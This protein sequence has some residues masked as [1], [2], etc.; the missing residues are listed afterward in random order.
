MERLGIA[1]KKIIL[2]GNSAG[3]HLAALALL[4]RNLLAASGLN[5]SIVAALA[6]F[7]APLELRV[8]WS[9]PPLLMLTRMKNPVLFKL[10]NPIY[11]L[12]TAQEI[13]ILL[14]HGEKDG[15]VENENSV[16]FYDKLRELGSR[17]LQIETLKNGTHLDAAS[18]CFPDH[19]CS[20]V[21]REWLERVENRV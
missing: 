10:A 19:P 18:W 7:S 13:P 12:K 16:V 4:D 8:M 14:V 21:F 1:Q 15:F 9:S 6:C 2:C 17:D 20:Q 5:P 3:G 11:Y